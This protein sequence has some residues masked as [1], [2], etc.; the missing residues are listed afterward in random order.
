MTNRENILR[1]I[2]F[3]KPQSIPVIFHI[4]GACWNHYDWRALEDMK[5]SHQILFPGFSP[6]GKKPEMRYALND[7]AGAP[8]TDPWGCTWQTT[9]DGITG[10]V[11]KGPLEDW[12]AFD[13]YRPPDPEKTDG[14]RP[15]SWADVGRNFEKAKK[16]G[17]VLHGGLEHGHTFLRLAYLRGYENLLFDMHDDEPRLAKLIGMVFGFQMARIAGL[18]RAGAEIIGIPEDL[19]MQH[20]PML[21]PEMFRK[22]IRPCYKKYCRAVRDAGALVHMHSDGDIR[23]LMGDL[24]ECGIDAMNL[25]DLVNGLDWIRDNLKGKVCIDLDIDRQS[26]TR[27]GSPKEIDELIRKEVET[28]GSRQGGLTMIYGMYPGVPLENAKALMDAMEKYSALWSD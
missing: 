2:K 4:N 3:G 15:S 21:S 26:V 11:T 20:G 10:S 8:W 27:F 16:S 19:G 13:G 9:D 7:K 5:A 18:V 24:L 1:A 22:Y 6:G 23:Q 17:G 25:Q 12:A 14:I 28:L